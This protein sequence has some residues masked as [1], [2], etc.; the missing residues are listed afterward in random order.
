MNKPDMNQWKKL[1]DLANELKQLKPWEFMFEDEIF[2][3]QDPVSGETSF[4]S[5]MGYAEMHYGVSFYQGAKGLAG[6]QNLQENPEKIY[7]TF[8]EIPQLNLGFNSRDQIDKETYA[9]IKQLGLKYRGSQS[10]PLFRSH[11]PGMI[12][13]QLT[14]R[15]ADVLI[16]A[17]D[18]VLKMIARIQINPQL[19]KCKKNHHV[20]AVPVKKGSS[21]SWEDQVLRVPDH[22]PFHSDYQPHPD[23]VMKYRNQ[24]AKNNILEVDLFVLPSFIEEEGRLVLPYCLLIVDSNSALVLGYEIFC[25]KTTLDDMFREVS[26]SF[27]NMIADL[28]FR[29]QR[30]KAHSDRTVE[31]MRPVTD[32][33]DLKVT[34]SQNLATL[35]SARDSLIQMFTA[36][37]GDDELF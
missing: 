3:I 6:F 35:N 28:G 18:Q 25:V 31:I 16:V 5:I 20:V 33:L 34:L 1:Y 13:G 7:M 30:I 10:W 15:E 29:P 37:G 17:L 27:L 26:E 14:M 32:A 2:G 12:P 4:A 19:L 23:S 21:L 9:V 36:T 24:P 11:H 22:V 8:F